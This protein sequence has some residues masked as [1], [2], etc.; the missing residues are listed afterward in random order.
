MSKANTSLAPT[1]YHPGVNLTTKKATHSF[2]IQALQNQKARH[3]RTQ[4][5]YYI[6]TPP[7][8]H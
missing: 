7:Y 4:K 2:V 6:A 8:I 5:T 3:S 1:Q